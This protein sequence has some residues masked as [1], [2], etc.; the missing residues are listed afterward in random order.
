MALTKEELQH[1]LVVEFD[2]T[3]IKGYDLLVK[4]AAKRLAAEGVKLDSIAAAKFLVG[5]PFAVGLRD[6]CAAQGQETVDVP[7]VVGEINA[8]FAEA[9]NAGLDAIPAGFRDFAKKFLSC[10]VA[11]K[12]LLVTRGNADKVKEALGI[13][14]ENLLVTADESALFGATS[15]EAFRI[16]CHRGNADERLSVAVVGSGASVKAAVGAAMGALA[17]VTPAN[18]WQDFT[19]ADVLF[20]EFKG[21]LFADVER[22]LR[23]KA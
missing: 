4:T 10:G 20:D 11:T 21:G 2:W 5:K 19:G 14:S 6:L 23:L 7:T 3:V 16:L 13:D 9:V 8:A 15:Y 18:E 1:T 22:L 17:Q 12:I